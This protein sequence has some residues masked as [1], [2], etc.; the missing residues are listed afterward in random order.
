MG[1]ISF[2]IIFLEIKKRNI[3][4]IN[5]LNRKRFEDFVTYAFNQYAPNVAEGLKKVLGKQPKF[6]TNA[7]PSEIDFKDWLTLFGL[8]LKVPENRQNIVK[9][10]FANQLKQQKKIEKIHR[11]RVDKSW[12]KYRN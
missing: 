8:F 5:N 6:S 9:D 7:K 12:R 3:P 2:E 10:S 11:T 4:L 1:E